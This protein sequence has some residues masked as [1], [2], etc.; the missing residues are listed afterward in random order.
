MGLH[1]QRTKYMVMSLVRYIFRHYLVEISSISLQ[2]P[3][4]YCLINN[5]NQLSH[6]LVFHLRALLLIIKTN[7]VMISIFPHAILYN[8]IRRYTEILN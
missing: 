5:I 8:K 7:A 4:F 2:V 1:T 6:Q 3:Y